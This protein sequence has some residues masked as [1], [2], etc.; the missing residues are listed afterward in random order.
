VRPPAA[1]A[2]L[3][4][5]V[6]GVIAS[7]LIAAVAASHGTF[8]H[9]STVIE[10]TSAAPASVATTIPAG[11]FDPAAIYR[12]RIQGVVTITSIFPSSEAGG[13]GF[14]VSS[15]GLIMTNAHVVT[16]SA[17]AG[18]SPSD[19][20]PA[21]HVYVRFSG[22]DQ[23][24]ASVVGFDLFSDVAIVRADTAGRRLTP[25]PLGDS[26][27]VLVGEPVAAIGSPFLE[28][29]SLSVGMVSADADG[30]VIGI[31]SQIQS[32]S[33]GGEGVGFAVPIDLARHS[34]TQIVKTGHVAYGWL[35]VRLSTVTPTIA[36]HFHLATRQGALVV[37]V[38]NGG[39]AD[40]AGLQAGDVIMRLDGRP[41]RS[42]AAFGAVLARLRP[43]E[44]VAVTV[45][46]QGGERTVTV[47]L[48]EL[49][50]R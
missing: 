35:G 25:V 15:D 12:S 33:G 47:T 10:Q 37:G 23:V 11:R 16:N 2:A 48:G 3:A 13:S 50:V 29:G 18:V 4:G 5:F 28:A 49:P 20:R 19:V 8:D 42:E 21:D 24:D 41:T 1:I 38:T 26:S 30:D 32:T 36:E 7:L 14:V 31:N 34:M 27:R 9:T 44:R 22:G 43:G 6:A 45:V 39:P 46:G 40:R 17:D